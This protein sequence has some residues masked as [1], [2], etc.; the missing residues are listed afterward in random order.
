MEFDCGSSMS[1]LETMQYFKKLG[2]N[3]K[4]IWWNFNSRN[5][6][7]PETD[8]YGN[9]FLSGYNPM[10]LKFF[11]KKERKKYEQFERNFRSRR[12]QEVYREW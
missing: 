11:Q 10:L 7:C 2:V 6:T 9:I 8:K 4:I 1:T 5:T 12:E 3:T